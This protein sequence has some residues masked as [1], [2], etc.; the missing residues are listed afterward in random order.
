MVERGQVRPYPAA[1]GGRGGVLSSDGNV[2][3]LSGDAAARGLAATA[4]VFAYSTTTGNYSLCPQARPPPRAPRRRGAAR[5]AAQG[6]LL[7]RR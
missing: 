1:L 2:A 7:L 3:V 5:C 4:Y 6:R